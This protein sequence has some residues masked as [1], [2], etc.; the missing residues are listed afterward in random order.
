MTLNHGQRCVDLLPDDLTI[1][2]ESMEKQLKCIKLKKDI[3]PENIP[4]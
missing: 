4:V 1:A 3:G 2:I